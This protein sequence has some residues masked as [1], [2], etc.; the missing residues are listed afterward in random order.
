MSYRMSYRKSW[1]LALGAPL[2]AVLLIAACG[3]DE[4]EAKATPRP[5]GPAAELAPVADIFSRVKSFKA[6]ITIETPG[7]AKQEAT[8][9]V[10]VPDRLQFKLGTTE[11]IGI[12]ADNYVKIAADWAKTP[13]GVDLPLSPSEIST[14]LRELT[15]SEVTKGASE[16]VDGKRCQVYNVTHPGGRKA[17]YCISSD[18]LVLR[19]V[20]QEGTAKITVVFSDF[21]ATFEIRP[22]I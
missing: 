15:R 10:I 1:L 16:T 22:P 6:A 21:N 12:G 14:Q 11:Y 4:E 9:A 5:S 13:R 18:N 20:S 17:E 19:Y 7:Q 8:L 2:L 3:D